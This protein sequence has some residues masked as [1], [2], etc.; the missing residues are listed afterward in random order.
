[1]TSGSLS[2]VAPVLGG[3]RP[4][5]GHPRAL[6]SGSPDLCSNCRERPAGVDGRCE[7]CAEQYADWR[8]DARAELEARS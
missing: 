7:S 8:D 3:A 1:M 2:I 4:S 6:A 5:S